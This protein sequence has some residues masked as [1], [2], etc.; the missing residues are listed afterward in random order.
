MNSLSVKQLGQGYTR[1][2]TRHVLFIVFS[3]LAKLWMLI[4]I[5]WAPLKSKGVLLSA[6]LGVLGM[7]LGAFSSPSP[8]LSMLVLS[9]VAEGIRF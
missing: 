3:L 7:V 2:Q 9:W 1:F 4:L 6:V 8:K 5:A